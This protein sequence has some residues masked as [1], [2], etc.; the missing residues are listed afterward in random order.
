MPLVGIRKRT[1]M[2][3]A[4]AVAILFALAA[5]LAGC[6][7]QPQTGTGPINQPP[8]FFPVTPVTRAGEATSDLYDLTF[9]IA[10]IVFVLVEGLLIWITIRYRRRPTDTELPKQTHGSNPLEILWTIVPAI[11]VTL[12][13]IAALIT[14]N[15]QAEASSTSPS[16]VI[17]VTGFQWQWTFKYP[18]QGLSFTGTGRDGPVMA[19]PVDEQIRIRLMATDVIHSFY[20]PQ[21]LYK[22]D[23]VPGRVNEFDVVVNDVGTYTGQ[24]AEFCGLSHAD[25]RFSV[26]AMTRADFDAWVIEQQ[27]AIPTAGPSAPPGAPSVTVTSV[28]ILAGFDPN[29]L[30]APANVPWVVQLTNAD[31][32]VPHDFSIRGANPDGSDWQGDPDAPGGGSATY[33]PPPLKPGE[34]EFYCSIH[35]NMVGTLKAQ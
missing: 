27:Q 33:Q 7:G 30:T 16:V 1:S 32:A 25:M 8:G 19:L 34:Y 24:C 9:A 22:K 17:E 28:G 5:L 14:L 6:A 31:P 35:T 29:Q 12:L 15:E 2:T 4:S 10:V 3:I 21:F 11:T 20:V 26:E 23:V 18:D 13:F